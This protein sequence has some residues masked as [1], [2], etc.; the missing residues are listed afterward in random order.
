MF[1]FIS[2][3]WTEVYLPGPWDLALAHRSQLQQ[4]IPEPGMG[5]QL[6]PLQ[7]RLEQVKVVPPSAAEQ[8][9]KKSPHPA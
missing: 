2:Q 3:S 1:L 5:L 6:P 7:R 4:W 9:P 8:Q